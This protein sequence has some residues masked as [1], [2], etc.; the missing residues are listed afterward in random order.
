MRMQNREEN[1]EL[2]ADI[3]KVVR[4]GSG[5]QLMVEIG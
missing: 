1:A 3:I 2:C 5:S 4:D